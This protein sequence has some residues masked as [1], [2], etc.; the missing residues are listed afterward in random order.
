VLEVLDGEAAVPSGELHPLMERSWIESGDLNI[1][2]MRRSENSENR[3]GG[4]RRPY[5]D[6]TSSCESEPSVGPHCRVEQPHLAR[7]LLLVLVREF[8]LRD[9]FSPEGKMLSLKMAKPLL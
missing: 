7:G 8:E 2:W 1:E 3:P 6:W 4:T 9:R 5:S